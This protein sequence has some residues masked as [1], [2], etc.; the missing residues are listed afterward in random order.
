[1]KP[2]T[3]KQLGLIQWMVRMHKPELEKLGGY[4]DLKK[5]NVLNASILIDYL[6]NEEWDYA[7]KTIKEFA[8]E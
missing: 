7:E 1:M 4:K 2:A 5:L 3:F 8:P 6:K